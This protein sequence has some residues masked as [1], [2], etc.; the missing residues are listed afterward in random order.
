MILLGAFILV[1]VYWI[2]NQGVD[3]SSIQADTSSGYQAV[4]IDN[5]QVYFGKLDQDS[6]SLYVLT[7]VFY[8]QTGVVSI[9]QTANLALT[10]LGSEAHGPTDE[11]RINPDHILFIEDMK[12]DSK[13]V[14]AINQYKRSN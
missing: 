1:G 7:E 4:F 5:G 2:V 13:V 6:G 10:K 9:D 8:L 11:M 12:R 3:P 14:E